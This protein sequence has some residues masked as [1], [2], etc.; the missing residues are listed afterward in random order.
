MYMHVGFLILVG[1]QSLIPRLRACKNVC[2][3][4]LY[5]E[6]SYIIAF[7]NDRGS[8]L[9]FINL[10]GSVSDCEASQQY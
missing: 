10:I 4:K 9:I 3:A 8:V 1:I 7:A 5:E 2:Q 6:T